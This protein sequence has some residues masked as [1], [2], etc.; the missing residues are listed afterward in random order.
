MVSWEWPGSFDTPRTGPMTVWDNSAMSSG[1]LEALL[2]SPDA[3]EAAL[4]ARFAALG[5][6]WKIHAH[7]P[8]FTVEEARAL[9]FRGERRAH[10]DYEQYR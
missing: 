8:V 2:P 3:R 7:A 1:S 6:E 9:M 10:R 4:Y 5:I